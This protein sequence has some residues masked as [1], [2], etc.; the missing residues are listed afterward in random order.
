MTYAA[1]RDIN[2]RGPKLAAELRELGA[3][4]ALLVP[5]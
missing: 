1:Q 3:D 5:V 4:A 2:E